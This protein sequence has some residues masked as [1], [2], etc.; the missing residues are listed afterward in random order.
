[1]QI[2]RERLSQALRDIATIELDSFNGVGRSISFSKAADAIDKKAPAV[3]KSVQDIENI[4]FVG[5][6]TKKVLIDL[7]KKQNPIQN[8][9]K[10]IRTRSKTEKKSSRRTSSSKKSTSISKVKIENLTHALRRMS[11]KK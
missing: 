6:S 4:K 2:R 8:R 1:M 3:I 11:R 10:V 7:L 5:P 9:K